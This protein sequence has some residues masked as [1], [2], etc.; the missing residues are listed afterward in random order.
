[1]VLADATNTFPNL[2]TL[3]MNSFYD[4]VPILPLSAFFSHLSTLILDG[5]REVEIAY[6]ALIAALLNCTPQLESLWN[7]A[8]LLADHV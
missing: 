6:P 1:M 5:S 7:E 4:C 3:H 8:A 2:Q